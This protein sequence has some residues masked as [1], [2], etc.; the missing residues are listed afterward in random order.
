MR[1]VVQRLEERINLGPAM[2]TNSDGGVPVL[3]AIVD[4]NVE[5]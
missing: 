3:P 5:G 2:A 1:G 4:N